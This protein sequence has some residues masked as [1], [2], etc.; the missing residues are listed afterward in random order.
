M[1]HR[2]LAALIAAVI[3]CPAVALAQ[4]LPATPDPAECVVEPR[5]ASFFEPLVAEILTATPTARHDATPLAPEEAGE[6]VDAATEAEVVALLRQV[7]A[8]ANAGDFPRLAALFTDDAAREAV[9]VGW[10]RSIRAAN[11]TRV[12][13]GA[14]VLSE[15][16]LLNI[17]MR[18][19]LSRPAGS[20]PGVLVAVE[21]VS[22]LPD[23][24]VAATVDRT[25]A[26][27]SDL[28]TRVV[29]ERDGGRF[30]LDQE[31]AGSLQGT[32]I[33]SSRPSG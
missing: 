27:G 28:G 33:P 4:S 10:G 1:L 21:D 9:L 8:C 23:G 25:L 26:D 19:G 2:L 6:P 12:R 16:E 32:P 5:P 29:V 11:R 18:S 3:P 13:S 22:R 15:A 31:T 17:I 20:S 24:R 30:L 14:E 7:V